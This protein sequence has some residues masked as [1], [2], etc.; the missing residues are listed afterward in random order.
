M[1]AISKNMRGNEQSQAKFQECGIRYENTWTFCKN[2]ISSSI[3]RMQQFQ[4]DKEI[5]T[6]SEAEIFGVIMTTKYLFRQ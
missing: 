5:Y 3:T 6:K 1:P 4:L 2:I